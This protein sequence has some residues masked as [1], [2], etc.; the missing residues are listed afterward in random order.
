MLLKALTIVL[1]V[2]IVLTRGICVISPTL[3]RRLMKGL[4]DR[5]LVML[6]MGPALAVYGAALFWAARLAVTGEGA[7]LSF[8]R[9]FWGF[10]LGAWMAIGGLAL[11]AA[12]G[13]FTRMLN[14][15]LGRSDTVLR[16][17]MLI[18]V[19]LGLAVLTLGIWVY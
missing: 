16:L 8:A 11:L 1:G 17:L 19:V 13:L 7:T 2:M 5:K 9:G 6:V 4:I 12:P 14:Y 3:S 10:F 18:G 15:F